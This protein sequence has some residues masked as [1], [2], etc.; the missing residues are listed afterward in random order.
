MSDRITEARRKAK[1]QRFERFAVDLSSLSTCKRAAVGC[2][3]VNV[4]LTEV[5]SIGYN[6][7]PSGMPNGGCREVQ[8]RCGCV[9]AEANALVKLS[10]RR[11][12]ILI[13]TTSPCEACAGLIA[14]R[15]GII[16]VRY[17][18]EYRDTKPMR[19]LQSAGIHIVQ[20]TKD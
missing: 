12:A 6:G 11:P 17:M 1:L 16:E 7:Q 3:I 15:G 13:T 14:N 10:D 8:G 19:I 5:F 4:E 9:H 2:V 20:V 18:C